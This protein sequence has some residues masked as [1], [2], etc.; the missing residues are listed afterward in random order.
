MRSKSNRFP[1]FILS[2]LAL[3]LLVAASAQ[4][5]QLPRSVAIGTNPPGTLF[6]AAAS[7]ISKVTSEVLPFQVLVQP[8]SGSSTF[9]PLLNSGELEF[10]IN[11]AV[12]MGLSYGGPAVKIGGRNPLPH[13]PNARLAMRGGP[14]L[15]GLLVKKDS[16][17]KTV[18]D[19]KGQR[20]TGEYPAH[21]AVWYNMYGA[22]TSA[23]LTWNDVKVVPVPA[24]NDGVEALGQG[25]AEVSISALGVAK[26]KEVDAAIGL[27]HMSIDC[28]PEG[29]KRLRKGVPGY[30]PH[31]V[32]AGSST[33]VV[34]DTCVIAY[35]VYLTVGKSVPNPVV[36]AVL[37]GIW[38]N[39][40]KL[41]PI[42]PHLRQWN[43]ERAVD[44]DV[45]IPYHPA[46]AAFYKER[47]QWSAKMD[48]AQKRLLAMNP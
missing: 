5:Q 11:N 47:G 48:D 19:L 40:E 20:V 46:A 38:E 21:L 25:R 6:Y 27:R 24:V 45:T 35:D 10:G 37:K 16:P 14:L 13:T 41:G 18:H 42:H 39:F 44:E 12:D 15:I 1:R 33:A 30:Y 22:L 2:L 8:Y 7:G 9:L 36:S 17:I 23:G 4:A 34:E 29:E 31:R 28:S 26:V 32:K 43:R 3:A